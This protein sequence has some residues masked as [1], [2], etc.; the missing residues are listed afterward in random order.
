MNRWRQILVYLEPLF[1]LLYHPHCSH[2]PLLVPR[3]V[4]LN[5]YRPRACALQAQALVC[6]I[7]FDAR[8]SRSSGALVKAI[9]CRQPG[10][11]KQIGFFQVNN[12]NVVSPASVLHIIQAID[13]WCDFLSAS[14]SL[15]AKSMMVFSSSVILCSTAVMCDGW[16]S[17]I[18]EIFSKVSV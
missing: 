17:S 15:P 1:K 7:N 10:F 8:F 3:I 14:A 12:P 11:E 16:F 6:A 13:H 5:Y 9:Q 2:C 4:K 18:D